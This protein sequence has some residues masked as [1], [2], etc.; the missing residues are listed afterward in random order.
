MRTEGSLSLAGNLTGLS[1]VRVPI[2]GGM[3]EGLIVF[4]GGPFL[5][6]DPGR[7]AVPRL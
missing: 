5:G 7:P 4:V 3:V 1:E 2:L 6:A